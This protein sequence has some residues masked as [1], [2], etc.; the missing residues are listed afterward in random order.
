MVAVVAYVVEGEGR[1]RADPLLDHEVPL[2][3]HRHFNGI[4]AI[5]V[6]QGEA[7]GREVSHSSSI[8]EHLGEGSVGLCGCGEDAAGYIGIYTRPTPRQ[9]ADLGPPETSKNCE[10]VIARWVGGKVVSNLAGEG[11]GEQPE[12]AP[13]NRILQ[14]EG[15]PGKTYARLVQN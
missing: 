7:A 10:A 4:G 1:V 6:W 8:G 13:K 3:V 14:T 2:F 15:S 12:A 11:V 5:D 9:S